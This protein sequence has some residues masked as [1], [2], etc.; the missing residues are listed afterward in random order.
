MAGGGE[1]PIPATLGAEPRAHEDLV[2]GNGD[3]DHHRGLRVLRGADPQLPH[4]A[5]FAQR[6]G[7]EYRH[8]EISRGR[9]GPPRNAAVAADIGRH[10]PVTISPYNL[11]GPMSGSHKCSTAI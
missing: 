10:A 4:I 1:I 11:H 3:P 6:V 2:V 7:I 9:G 5:Q 8:A